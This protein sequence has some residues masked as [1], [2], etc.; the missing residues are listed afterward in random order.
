MQ[1]V[2]RMC[3]IPRIFFQSVKNKQDICLYHPYNPTGQEKKQERSH[4]S[5]D[6]L[7]W[8]MRVQINAAFIHWSRQF[9]PW[10]EGQPLLQRLLP[11]V[12]AKL[13]PALPAIIADTELLGTTKRA[14]LLSPIRSR[15][16]FN[17]SSNGYGFTVGFL[18]PW[19]F[20]WFFRWACMATLIVSRVS[21]TI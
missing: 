20:V 9:K 2:L 19:Y 17:L 1:G 5:P 18:W 11:V 8:I 13:H 16:T 15:N 21:E 4:D 7:T 6:P 3:S 14:S 10:L 12:S